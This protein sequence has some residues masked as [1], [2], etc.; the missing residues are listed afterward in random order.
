MKFKAML[1]ALGFKN[2]AKD[3]KP[4]EIVGALEELGGEPVDP[5][6]NAAKDAEAEEA[7][8]KEMEAKD[9]VKH[10]ADCPCKDCMDKAAKDKAAKD[11]EEPDDKNVEKIEAEEKSEGDKKAGKDE[12]EILPSSEHGQRVFHV[13]D[14][15]TCLNQIRPLIAK[16]KDQGVKDAFNKLVRNVKTLRAGVK[17][18]LP[19]PFAALTRISSNAGTDSEPE[20]AM[21]EF[22]NGKSYADGLKAWNEYQ[23]ERA[24]RQR[25]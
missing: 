8:K 3:A 5:A 11:A 18:G 25:A 19:D 4:E 17:D 2:W 7:K 15:A 10:A 14:A 23:T 24:K 9:A 12:A 21:F 22:F 20:V 6:K 1:T 13:G 16:C